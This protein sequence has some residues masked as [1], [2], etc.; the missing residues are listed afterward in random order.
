M[1]NTA[2]HANIDIFMNAMQEIQNILNNKRKK[3]MGD[4]NM[5]LLKI[6]SNAKTQ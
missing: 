6:K 4:M 2:P 1:P 5:N 3:C